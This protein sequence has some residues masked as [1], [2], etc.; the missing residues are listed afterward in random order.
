LFS[1]V[2]FSVQKVKRVPRD[3]WKTGKKI[4]RETA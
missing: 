1:N 4:P 3:S 2:L